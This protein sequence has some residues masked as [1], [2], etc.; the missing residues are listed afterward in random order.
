M[1]Q[2]GKKGFKYKTASRPSRKAIRTAHVNDQEWKQTKMMP[3]RSLDTNTLDCAI[4]K[5]GLDCCY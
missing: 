1:S 2:S 5:V 4:I 3:L